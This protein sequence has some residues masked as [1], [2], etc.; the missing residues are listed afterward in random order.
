MKFS[1]APDRDGSHDFDFFFGSW[2][3]HHRRLRERLTGCAEWVEFGG[4]VTTQPLL[5]GAGNVDDNVLDL[6]GGA[7]RAATLRAYDAVKHCWS[8]WW[9]DGRQPGKLDVP[10]EG[11]FVDGT[12]TFYA[13]DTLNGR[14]IRVRFCW[15]RTSTTTPRWEQAFSPDAG[16]SW[17]TNWTMDFFRSAA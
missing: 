2:R 4:T 9:L 10:V 15:L 13:E 14:P 17:E 1:P 12:G 16:Q 11:G 5:G 6:P 7:Y 3:V 8:I